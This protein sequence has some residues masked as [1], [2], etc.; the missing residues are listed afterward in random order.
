MPIFLL[1]VLVELEVEKNCCQAKSNQEISE[2]R[3]GLSSGS[4]LVEM[5]G[6]RQDRCAKEES[7]ANRHQR[8]SLQHHKQNA[9]HHKQDT[10]YDP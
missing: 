10:Y 3:N 4:A 7:V 2:R 9:A 1:N 5:I 8:M 6:K